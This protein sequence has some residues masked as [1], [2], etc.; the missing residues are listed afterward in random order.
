MNCHELCLDKKSFF[1]RKCI[2]KKALAFQRV[3]E[4]NLWMLSRIFKRIY[5]WFGLDLRSLA[6]Y[7]ILLGFFVLCDLFWRIQDLGVHYTDNGILS[8]LAFFQELAHPWS[9]SL[10]FSN[11]GSFFIGV[12]FL[13]H[14]FCALMVLLGKRTRLFTFLLFVMTV[15]VHN[16]NWFLNNGGDDVLRAILFISIFLPW[17]EKFSQD[18]L[19]GN[20]RVCVSFWSLTLFFQAFAIYFFGYI[21]KNSA[22]WRSEFTA[23]QYAGN[24]DIFSTSIGIWLR[25]FPG[26]MKALTIYTIFLEYFGPLLLVFGWI[27]K[28]HSPLVRMLVV[29]LFVS[30]HVGIFTMMNIGLFPFYC[31][32]LW[33]AFIPSDFWDRWFPSFQSF[34][35]RHFEKGKLKAKALSKLTIVSME[36]F[37]VF[38]F[39]A[40]ISW[41]LTTLKVLNYQSPFFS[42]VIRY[43]HLYQEWNMFSPYPKQDNF[44]I[45]MPSELENGESIELLSKSKDIY[46]SKEKVFYAQIHHEKW[47]KFYLNLSENEKLAKIY[48]GYWCRKWNER[49]EGFS[50]SRLRKISINVFAKR[51]MLN[52]SESSPIKRNLWNHWCFENDV[53]LDKLKVK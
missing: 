22:I 12:L 46:S 47:R 14:A 24:L 43:L 10:H 21:L 8:R 48:S 20:K 41:N 15:S 35:K 29:I 4:D 30:L 3:F 23:L 13:F 39:I 9:F 53:I 17:G 52:G 36:V 5:L 2:A 33:C 45:E 50:S 25:Q 44:W 18:Y 11:G 42:K 38:I 19:S 16:R 28:K 32:A 34:L 49:N 27:F 1:N 37:G 51:I 26:L 31:I 40:L 7:R 6:L